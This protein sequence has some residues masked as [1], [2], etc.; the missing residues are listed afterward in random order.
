M[1]FDTYNIDPKGKAAA[2]FGQGRL[3]GKPIS[4]WLTAQGAK[5]NMIDELTTNP[6]K[7]SLQADVIISGVGKPGLITADM[8]RDNAIVIDY[9]YGKKGKTMAGDVDFE[10]VAKK[11]SLITPVP[12]GMGPLVVAAVLKNLVTLQDKNV[13]S[14]T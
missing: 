1:L 3:V 4:H 9:G 5:V 6:E 7:L 11:S 2:V 8:V 14:V 13:S 10:N 12:G